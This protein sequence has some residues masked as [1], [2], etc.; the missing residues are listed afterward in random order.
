MS[1]VQ[2]HARGTDQP[3]VEDGLAQRLDMEFWS[4][5]GLIDPGTTLPRP[6]ADQLGRLTMNLAQTSP[7]LIDADWRERRQHL[8]GQTRKAATDHVTHYTQ[9]LTDAADRNTRR[10]VIDLL[11]ELSEVRGVA[12]SDIAAALGI[13]VPALRKWRKSVSGTTPENHRGLAELTAFFDVLAGMVDSPARWMSMPLVSGF[14]VTAF[15]IYSAD[16]AARLL[17]LAA[18][19]AGVTA[20]G[21][22]DAVAPGW[23]DRWRSEYEVFEAADG[24]LSMR[25]RQA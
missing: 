1:E 20:A 11:T 12:W 18:A 8:S 3:R 13:S 10:S 2:V 9:W 7:E 21:L 16:H 14:N 19:N 17:D 22:L 6:N 23:R 5:L 24:E 25:P 4:R 15:D